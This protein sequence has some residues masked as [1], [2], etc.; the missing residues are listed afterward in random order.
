MAVRLHEQPLFLQVGQDTADRFPSESCK[1]GDDRAGKPDRQCHV[2]LTGYAQLPDQVKEG[3]D[4]SAGGIQHRLSAESVFE[5]VQLE[6]DLPEQRGQQS[7]IHLHSA[8]QILRFDKGHRR[9]DQCSS[10]DG[11]GLLAPQPIGQA[12]EFSDS[13]ALDRH[14]VAGFGQRGDD[15][16]PLADHGERGPRFAL[17]NH[18]FSSPVRFYLDAQWGTGIRGAIELRQDAVLPLH[19]VRTQIG[20]RQGSRTS[21]TPRL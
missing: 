15:D 5:R 1:F 19:A 10:R 14:F 9:L 8:E 20:K 21:L 7:R 13:T 18:V 16:Q 11:I 3:M 4:D 6:A 2:F 12:D 17:P